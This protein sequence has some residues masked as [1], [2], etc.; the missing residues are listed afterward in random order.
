MTE[1]CFVH[2]SHPTET[3]KSRFF[4]LGNVLE[5][6]PPSQGGKDA[7]AWCGLGSVWDHSM[8]DFSDLSVFGPVWTTRL[9]YVLRNF[10]VSDLMEI[11]A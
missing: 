7:H 2:D 6:E 1:P 3:P 11:L 9:Q 5:E 10:D 4:V 8:H